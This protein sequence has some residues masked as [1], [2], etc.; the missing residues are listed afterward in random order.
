MNRMNWVACAL[1]LNEWNV[2]GD[3]NECYDGGH[4]DNDCCVD[5]VGFGHHDSC[6]CIDD[7]DDDDDCVRD[8]DEAVVAKQL[9]VKDWLK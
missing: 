4:Y 3:G 5:Y 2:D 9:C 6:V 1:Q 7:D 8:G